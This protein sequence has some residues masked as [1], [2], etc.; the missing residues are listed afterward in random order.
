VVIKAATT[1]FF[2]GFLGIVGGVLCDSFLTFKI[3]MGVAL[4]SFCVL[5]LYL[6]WKGKGA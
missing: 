5:P 1:T 6:V 4:T 3:G 2:C